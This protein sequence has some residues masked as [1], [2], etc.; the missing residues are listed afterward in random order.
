MEDE[1]DKLRNIYSQGNDIPL[2]KQDEKRFANQFSTKKTWL[3][4]CQTQPDCVWN[5]GVWF[6]QSTPK[7]FF[8]LWVAVQNRLQTCDRMQRW[9][10]Q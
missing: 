2:W 1:I 7:F 4:M 6:S 3:Y 5:T 9:M 8:L 10:Q